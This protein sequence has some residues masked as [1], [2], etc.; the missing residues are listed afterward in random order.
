LFFRKAF[1]IVLSFVVFQKPFSFQYLFGGL[2]VLLGIFLNLSAKNKNNF[3]NLTLEKAF[4]LDK[5]VQ[6]NQ[7]P[8]KQ[9]EVWPPKKIF[10]NTFKIWN[11]FYKIQSKLWWPLDDIVDQIEFLILIWFW[12][13]YTWHEKVFE[14]NVIF[15]TFDG[16]FCF[17][18]ILQ[19]LRWFQCQTF[20]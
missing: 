13:A 6:E 20:Q 7:R 4:R 11:W 15:F 9:S 5:K 19:M 12:T 1:S 3:I 17:Y 16:P 8:S 2:I 10:F 18:L 14:N